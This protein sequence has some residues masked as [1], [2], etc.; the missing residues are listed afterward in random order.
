MIGG[1]AIGQHA[2]GEFIANS[3][4][5]LYFEPVSR[6]TSGGTF[7]LPANVPV[8]GVDLIWDDEQDVIWDNESNIGLELR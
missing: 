3:P 1:A 4:A 6:I 7:Q 5:P 8:L 2:V